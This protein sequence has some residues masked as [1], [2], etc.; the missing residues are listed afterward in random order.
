MTKSQFINLKPKTVIFN[1]D[2][3]LMFIVESSFINP[4]LDIIKDSDVLICKEFFL[5]KESIGILVE[6][7]KKWTQYRLDTFLDD[8]DQKIINKLLFKKILHLET[9]LKTISNILI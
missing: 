9:K 6:D 2:E 1:N 4:S 5:Q 7:C 3:R 8:L